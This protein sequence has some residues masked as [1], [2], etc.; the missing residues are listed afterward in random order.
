[1]KLSDQIK[2]DMKAAMKGKDTRTLGMLR[3]LLASIKNKAIEL[4]RE[5]DDAEVISVVRS[6]LKKLKDALEDFTKAARQDLID[7]TKEEIEVLKKFL[8]PQMTDDE[9]R[10]KV[11][12]KLKAIGATDM[13]EMGKAMG[14]LMK[15]LKDTV[16][17]SR[18][19]KMVEEVLKAK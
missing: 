15:D 2:E 5:L 19:K 10:E 6:D 7:K 1:M 9:L 14:Q 16:D 17:G 13:S 4:R 12:A 18:V 11:K 8:P 3:L